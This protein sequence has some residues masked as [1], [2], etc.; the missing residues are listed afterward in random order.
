MSD[1]N[2][3]ASG[4]D[5]DVDAGADSGAEQML[6]DA[7]QNNQGDES[8]AQEQDPAKALQ[9]E[10]DKWR[11]LARKHENASKTNAAAAKANADAAKKLAALE[12]SQ[13]SE[14]QKLTDRLSAAEVELAQYRTREV[15][16]NA[17]VAAGL[18]GEMAKFITEVEP[19][20][21]LEQ[22]QELAKHLK[23][24]APTPVE[25]KPADL[26][27]GARGAAAKPAGDPN[28]WLRNLAGR[29]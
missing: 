27:Q 7:L 13:K 24:A 25:P 14:Q 5:V 4:A 22:A 21:A 15:R 20:A 10:V 3:T 9:A 1:E 29:A 6:S 17:A 8:D 28:A 12:D 16:M 2:A 18:P 26:R 11:S 19:D 23:A